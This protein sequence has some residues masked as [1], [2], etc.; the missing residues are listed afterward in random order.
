MFLNFE[1]NAEEIKI[2]KN[3]LTIIQNVKSYGVSLDHDKNIYIPD[4]KNNLVVVIDNNHK[5]INTLENKKDILINNPHL[6]AFFKKKLVL[7][8]LGKKTIT[9]I[10]F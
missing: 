7:V 3:N 10:L 4:F 1:T 8:N 6:I 5:E 9:E 2:K